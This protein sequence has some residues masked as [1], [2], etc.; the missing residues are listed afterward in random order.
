[1]AAR[2]LIP[3]L[4]L[5]LLPTLAACQEK[6]PAA[7]DKTT[8]MNIDGQAFTLELALTP[9]A[10]FKGLSDRDHIAAD[11][12]MLFVFPNVAVRQFVMR[13]CPNPID[14][15]FL[16]PGGRIVAMHAMKPE[17]NTPEGQL[18][19]YSSDWPAQFAIELKG[20]TL[21]RMHLKP[22]DKIDFAWDDVA[23]L[24]K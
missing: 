13:R 11:G 23:R 10:R 4:A 18:H 8:T 1:M 17:P 9:E 20:G 16:G 14:I 5:L 12:G 6:V 19:L 21:E 15:I 22:G 7:G 3:F 24:A 2:I